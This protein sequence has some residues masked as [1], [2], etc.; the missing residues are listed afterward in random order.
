MGRFKTGV[1]IQQ[2][3][4]FSLRCPKDVWL[5][6]GVALVLLAPTSA[7][8][9]GAP[10]VELKL[11]TLAPENSSLAQIFNEMNAEL[12]R[13]TGGKVGFKMFA[14]S[15]MGDEED[16]LRKIRAG[17]V[18]G[19]VFTSTALTDINP[20]LRAMLIPF[21]FKNTQE[22]DYVL[23][24]MDQQLRKKFGEKGYVVLGWP[25]L[26]FIYFLSTTP[27]AG[28]DDLK[29]KRVWAKAN[30]PMSQALIDRIGV[31]TVAVSVP[32]VLMGLQTNLVD[33]V[34]NS[35]YYALATQWNTQVKYLT[36]LPLT[37]IGGALLLDKKAFAKIP[38]HL[39]EKVMEICAKH[40]RRLIDKTRKDNSEAMDL[41]LKRGVKRITPSP[42]Q[43]QAFKNLSDAAMKDLDSKQ[44]PPEATSSVRRLIAECQTKQKN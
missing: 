23:E 24:K 17:A 35:P 34:Y 19:A 32:D 40:V 7:S 3:I 42:E 31:S 36:D 13:E 43:V 22:V 37:Y 44:L 28:L 9:A 16:V 11:A 21:I 18:Q 15:V 5:V 39:Q 27:V 4:R 2:W 38:Q 30:A 12:I 25:E 41:I 29:N 14:G 8:C 10:E 26:G 33:V 20:D 1:E 6:F